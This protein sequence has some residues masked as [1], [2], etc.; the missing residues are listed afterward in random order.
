MYQKKHPMGCFFC[1]N[2]LVIKKKSVSLQ[3]FSNLFL[4]WKKRI[5]LLLIARTAIT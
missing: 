5:S 1:A 2:I 3:R 4:R